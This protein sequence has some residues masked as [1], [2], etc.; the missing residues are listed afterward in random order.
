M[1][2][3]PELSIFRSSH[4]SS[5]SKDIP[6]WNISYMITKTISQSAMRIVKKVPSFEPIEKSIEIKVRI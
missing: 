2:V 4:R 3:K 6:P 1:W 5:H